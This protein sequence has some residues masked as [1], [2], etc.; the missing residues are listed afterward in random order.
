[1]AADAVSGRIIGTGFATAK[2]RRRHALCASKLEIPE[3]SD[4]PGCVQNSLP[5][6]GLLEIEN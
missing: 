5:G 6:Q 3:R 2:L 4:D 1:V